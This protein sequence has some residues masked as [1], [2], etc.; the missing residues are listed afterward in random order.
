MNKTV[1]LLVEGMGCQGCV[2]T[3]RDKLKAVPGVK[4]VKVTL[5]PPEA[6]VTF[7]SDHA[8]LAQLL[9][10]TAGAGY[11]LKLKDEPDGE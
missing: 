1:K 9:N 6:V 11:P 2:T 7:D 3:V 5:Q 4:D 10:A 8:T